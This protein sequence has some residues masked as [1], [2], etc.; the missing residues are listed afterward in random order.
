MRWRSEGMN[1]QHKIVLRVNDVRLG[2]IGSNSY[3]NSESR[4]MFRALYARLGCPWS[5]VM[6]LSARFATN[7]L[8]HEFKDS[9]SVIC[10]PFFS[11]AVLLRTR[12]LCLLLQDKSRPTNLSFDS[13]SKHIRNDSIYYA[14]ESKKLELQK[15][16]GKALFPSPVGKAEC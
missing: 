4:F 10:Y 3:A 14:I 2:L 12:T 1:C 6:W 5:T 9:V 13:W 8:L 15:L 11:L 16:E 7:V